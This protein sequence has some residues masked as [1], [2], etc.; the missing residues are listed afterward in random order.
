MKSN[1]LLIKLRASTSRKVGRILLNF[2]KF[3]C[4]PISRLMAARG[5]IAGLL[6]CFPQL[7]AGL[8]VFPFLWQAFTMIIIDP[9][10]PCDRPVRKDLKLH[11][12]GLYDTA[13]D[14]PMTMRSRD[15]MRVMR[16][17]RILNC[18]GVYRR[19]LT[20]LIKFCR[21]IFGLK[22]QQLN[23]DRMSGLPYNNNNNNNTKSLALSCSQLILGK[24][25]HELAQWI[26]D[27]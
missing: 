3:R 5:V 23:S 11:V 21:V 17:R 22:G 10:S 26:Y 15:A 7:F 2:V 14:K 13:L 8:S 20:I 9:R 4:C 27:R 25:A 6:S 24:E 1:A 16:D 19:C 18:S 12:L